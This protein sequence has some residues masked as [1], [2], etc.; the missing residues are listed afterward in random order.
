MQALRDRAEVFLERLD[1]EANRSLSDSAA[2]GGMTK[3][4]ICLEEMLEAAVGQAWGRDARELHKM[5]RD[6]GLMPSAGTYVRLLADRRITTSSSEHVLRELSRDARAGDAGL[7]GRLVELRNA[8]THPRA[9]PVHADPATGVLLREA[10]EW[11]SRVL[12]SVGTHEPSP[13]KEEYKLGYIEKFL[14]GAYDELRNAFQLPS[15][16]NWDGITA[17]VHPGQPVRTSVFR[18]DKTL[19]TFVVGRHDKCALFIRDRC[20]SARHALVVLSRREGEPTIVRV[21]DLASTDGIWTQEGRTHSSLVTDGSLA[22]NLGKSAFFVLLR[23]DISTQAVQLPGFDDLPFSHPLDEF[24]TTEHSVELGLSALRAAGKKA[25]LLTLSGLQATTNSAPGV[26]PTGRSGLLVFHQKGSA[27]PVMVETARL[28]SG[29]LIGR[30]HRC[31][32]NLGSVPLPEHI[33]RVHGILVEVAGSPMLFDLASTTGI[34]V[35]TDRVGWVDLD[36]HPRDARLGG[37][38]ELEWRSS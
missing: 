23:R 38:I 27:V 14:R 20:L 21:L 3:L 2:V 34:Q 25:T 28:R 30:A 7:L 26:G 33:S 36:K 22:V 15:D 6:A 4:G 10:Y 29:C 16:Q 19:A 5:I 1:K 12:A 17:L 11:F 8:N 32:I 18:I 37:T 9:L 35:K 13:S 31:H 24:N